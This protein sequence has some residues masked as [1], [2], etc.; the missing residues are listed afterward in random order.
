MSNT[1]Q[2]ERPRITVEE[3]QRIMA[4]ELT[5]RSRLGYTALLLSALFMSGVISAL[6]LTEPVLQLRTQI[7]F[8]LMVVIGLSWAFYA[9]W[10]LTRRRVLLAG[11]RIIAAR[12]AVTF[13][14]VFTLGSLTLGLW[15]AV[16][17]VAYAAAFFGA[18]MFVI[19]IALL[20]HARAAFTRLMERRRALEMELG[21]TERA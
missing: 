15:T 1:S 8:A 18:V 7:A 3:M 10:V 19:A 6:W 16:G 12:M 4:A 5:L 17:R 9:A 2:F 14:A 11:H 21:T 20:V 13:C